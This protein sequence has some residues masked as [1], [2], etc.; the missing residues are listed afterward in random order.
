MPI[1]SESVLLT[2]RELIALI[3]LLADDDSSIRERVTAQLIEAGPRALLMLGTT[4]YV[5]THAERVQVALCKV[6]Q[7]QVLTRL[8]SF[9]QE[10]P[11]TSVEDGA[12]LLAELMHPNLDRAGTYETIETLAEAAPRS[13]GGKNRTAGLKTLATYMYEECG[14]DGN[15]SDYDNPAN[16]LLNQVLVRRVGLPISLAVVYLAVCARLHV[17][18]EGVGLPFHFVLRLPGAGSQAYLDPFNQARLLN[19]ND[20]RDLVRAHGYEIT[21]NQFRAVSSLEITARIAR[22]LLL[23]YQKRG[24]TEDENLMRL[25]HKKIQP[26]TELVG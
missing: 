23:S 11:N 15:H 25:A 1:S 20:C 3:D 7:A 2:D 4:D 6:Q 9:G 12:L 5:G 16:S 19:E 14:F 22:N 21:H 13:I 17:P 10:A 26:G 18:L 24:D 8:K